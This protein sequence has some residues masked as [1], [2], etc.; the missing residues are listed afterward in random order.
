MITPP[1]LGYNGSWVGYSWAASTKAAA[2]FHVP[3]FPWKKPLSADE[4]AN[5]NG[6]AIWAGLGGINSGTIEQIGV[7]DHVTAGKVYWY[8]IY[9]FFPLPSVGIGGPISSGD[10]ILAKVSRSGFH[11]T[12]SLSDQGPGSKWSVT[13]KKDFRHVENTGEVVTEDYSYNGHY[14]NLTP[15]SPVTAKVSGNPSTQYYTPWGHAVHGN[16]TVAME[17]Y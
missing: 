15:F 1:Q 3:R 8:G 4:K 13:I 9:E 16:K 7:Y 5:R 11:Y 6:I 2:Q 14:H 10:Q 17:H 12:L